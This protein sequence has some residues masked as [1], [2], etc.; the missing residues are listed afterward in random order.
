MDIGTLLTAVS[1][2]ASTVAIPYVVQWAKQHPSIPLTADKVSIVRVV[3][4][5]LAVGVGFL[6]AWLAGDLASF[7]F[8]TALSTIT[9]SVMVFAASNGVYHVAIKEQSAAE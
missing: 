2:L 1:A 5:V 9:E 7:D 4:A 6:Q 8:N 3:T